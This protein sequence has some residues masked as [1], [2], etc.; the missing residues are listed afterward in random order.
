MGISWK[1][2]SFVSELLQNS[3]PQVLNFRLK[4]KQSLFEN[5]LRL[6]LAS[7]K[8]QIARSW[9]EISELQTYQPFLKEAGKMHQNKNMEYASSDQFCA[10]SHA[11]ILRKCCYWWDS[12]GEFKAWHGVRR[13]QRPKKELQQMA[14]EQWSHLDCA[15]VTNYSTFNAKKKNCLS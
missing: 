11:S 2:F 7:M 14:A 1:L 15:T 6:R 5:D 3:F 12:A 13:D 4:L 10:S 8:D 9:P